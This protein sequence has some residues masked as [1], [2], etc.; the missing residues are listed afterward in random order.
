MTTKSTVFSRGMGKRG[1]HTCTQISK[2]CM[3]ALV[4]MGLLCKGGDCPQKRGLSDVPFNERRFYNVG[5]QKRDTNYRR[6]SAFR[7]SNYRQQGVSC[8]KKH[9]TVPTKCKAIQRTSASGTVLERPL[10][11]RLLR[12]PLLLAWIR[13]AGPRQ[14]T[15]VLTALHTEA[16]FP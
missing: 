5:A 9:A 7:D 3:H 1:R 15:V 6:C 4:R 13:A 14:I 8:L 12:Q 16:I 11:L 2:Q 10:A